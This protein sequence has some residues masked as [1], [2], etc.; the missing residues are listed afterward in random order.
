MPEPGV[1][2][3]PPRV[4][5]WIDILS[6]EQLPLHSK[7]ERNQYQDVNAAG[8]PVMFGIPFTSRL[9]GAVRG[10]TAWITEGEAA[11]IR[12]Y[13]LDGELTDLVRIDEESR[14][15]TDQDVSEYL[16]ARAEGS[17][18]DRE[19]WEE[20]YSDVPIPGTMPAF[21]SLLADET[22][23]VWAARVHWNPA[24]PR[25]WVVF[26]AEGR[27]LGSVTTPGHLK[28]HQIGADFILGVATDSFGVER[29]ERYTLRRGTA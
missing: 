1:V 9:S 6:G 11:E 5:S 29:V 23:L 21:E 25:E 24:N 15:V 27:A 17:S 2:E 13:D 18:Q 12:V 28:I 19:Y 26:D 3:W 7:V 16:T 20:I 8:V 4:Y 10:T 22:G 14:S